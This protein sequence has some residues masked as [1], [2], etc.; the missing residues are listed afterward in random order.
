MQMLTD[1]LETGDKGATKAVNTLDQ[2]LT[3]DVKEQGEMRREV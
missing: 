2:K 1:W 3:L